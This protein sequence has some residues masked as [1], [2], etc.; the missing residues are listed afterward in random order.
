MNGRFRFKASVVMAVALLFVL[1]STSFGQ[2]LFEEVAAEV[3]L[4]FNGSCGG[5]FWVDYDRD[6]DLDLMRGVRFGAPDIIYR[7]DGGYFTALTNVGMPVNS[8]GGQLIPMDFDRDGDLD[9]FVNCHHTPIQM[10]VNNG[11]LFQDR[12]AQLGIQ[13]RTGARFCTWVDLNRDG[14]MDLLVDFR[15]GW[16]IYRNDNGTRFTDITSSTHLPHLDQSGYFAETDIDL[17]GDVDL[18]LTVIGTSNHLYVNYGNNAFVD[19]TGAAGLS[20]IPAD[21]GCAWV[22]FDHD[23]YPDLL[24]QGANYHGIWRNNRDGTFTEM[25]VHGTFTASWGT[26]PYG[27]LYAVADFDMDGKE[28]FYAAR[29][30][31]CGNGTAP[32]Q[33][34]RQTARDGLDIWFEDIAAA[35][36]MDMSA[37]GWPTWGDY[38][39]DGDLDLYVAMQNQPSKLF[40]NRLHDATDHFQVRVLGPEGE[41][42]RWH[43][44]VEVYPHGSDQVLKVSELNYSN[45]NRNGFNNYF[46]LDEHGS[47]DLRIHFTCGVVM[48]PADYPQLAG[49][50]PAQIGNLL[51]VRMGQIVHADETPVPA[52]AD[53]RLHPAFPNPFNATAT[54]TYSLPANSFARLAVYDIQGRHVADLA[55]GNLSAGEHT[56]VWDASGA[57]SGLYF[58]RLTAGTHCATAKAALIK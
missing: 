53:F 31:G 24:T 1:M 30:G 43:T 28:D 48:S 17:D 5:P 33:L 27:A 23:K 2:P 20:G 35:N 14:W 21:I 44:R 15:D 57:T 26:F 29:P 40:R 7:N 45:V 41:L 16:L 38:D 11:G 36:G 19:A 25:R 56:A 8:D 51:T 3:G 4:G 50:V 32:N 9:V 42:D 58:L 12:T 47:Y 22:D 34:F 39:G 54:I 52:L 49:I 46:V 55:R 37:D 6:G 13:G 18:Y 10:M